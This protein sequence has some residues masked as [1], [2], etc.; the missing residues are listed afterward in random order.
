MCA[1]GFNGLCTPLYS[2]NLKAWTK[3]PQCSDDVQPFQEVEARA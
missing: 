2:G 3:N 1:E